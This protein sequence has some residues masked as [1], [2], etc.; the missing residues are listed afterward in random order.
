MKRMTL[1]ATALCLILIATIGAGTVAAKQQ[2]NPRQAGASSVYFYDVAATDTHGKGKLVIDVDKH[3]F[4]FNG[5]GFTPSSQIALRARA[6]GSTD[7]VVFASGKA[8]PSG[9]LHIAG[10]WDAD[11]APAVVAAGVGSTWFPYTYGAPISE[12]W[13]ENDGWFV[14]KLACEYSTDNGATWTESS[15]TDGI[16]ITD[17]TSETL[18][19]LGVPYGALVKIHVIVVGGVGGASHKT[20]SEVFTYTSS[21]YPWYHYAKYSITGTIFKNSLDFWEIIETN[22]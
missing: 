4:V 18:G 9:N 12:L 15:H 5:Q 17:H 10:T 6:A 21:P 13:L 7:Y 8:T 20:G 3:T 16:V 11:A 19:D 22:I 14:A 1:I 2:E